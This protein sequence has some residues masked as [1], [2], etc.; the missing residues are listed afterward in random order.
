MKVLKLSARNLR[1]LT[2]A[3]MRVRN[4]ILVPF[5]LEGVAGIF[6]DYDAMIDPQGPYAEQ[7]AAV[8]GFTRDDVF[9]YDRQV[10]INMTD[11]EL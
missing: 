7:R 11:A 5:R 10:T 2:E 1:A 4:V 8:S 3:N 9:E 6:V